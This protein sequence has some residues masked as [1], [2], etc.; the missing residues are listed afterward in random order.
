MGLLGAI[1]HLAF[2]PL[3]AGP[4]KQVIE[5]QS[6]RETK[7]GDSASAWMTKRVGV[8]RM[9]MLVANLPRCLDFFS[10]GRIDSVI[11]YNRTWR[12]SLQR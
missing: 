11:Y 4:V 12:Q 1:R 10:W 9:R 3:V 5:G 7:K 2:V 8:H 6:E